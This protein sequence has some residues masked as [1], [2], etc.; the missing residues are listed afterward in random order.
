MLEYHFNLKCDEAQ[1]GQECLLMMQDQILDTKDCKK[2]MGYKIIFMDLEMPVLNGLKVMIFLN[3]KA[4]QK[5][6]KL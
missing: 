4:T 3:L 5:I 2:C 1:N 6:R